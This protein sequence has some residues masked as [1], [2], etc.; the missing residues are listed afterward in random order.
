M[1]ITCPTSKYQGLEIAARSGNLEQLKTF[2]P[3]YM[4]SMASGRQKE[5]SA[6]AAGSGNLECLRSL[7]SPHVKSNLGC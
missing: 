5:L 7:V 2:T 4:C 1:V 6:L 3:K